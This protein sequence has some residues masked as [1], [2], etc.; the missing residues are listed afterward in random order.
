M[1]SKLIR[2]NVLLILW[3]C[4]LVD[5]AASFEGGLLIHMQCMTFKVEADIHSDGKNGV[6]KMGMLLRGM[7]RWRDSPGSFRRISDR[8]RAD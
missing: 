7:E 8:A 6:Q 1:K 3:A 2:S 4:G 5:G